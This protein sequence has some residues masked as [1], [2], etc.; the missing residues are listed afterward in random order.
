MANKW[1]NAVI[2]ICVLLAFGWWRM[3]Y[4]SAL[5]SE[6]RERELLP[7]PMSLDTRASLKQKG[8][9]STFGSLR[10]TLAAIMSLTATQYHVDS[11]WENLEREYKDI[12]LLDPGNVNYWDLGSWHIGTNA[13]VSSK[14]NTDYPPLK[15]QAMFEDYVHKGSDFLDQGILMSPKEW[16]LPF[17]KARMWANVHLIPDHELVLKTLRQALEYDN[18]PQMEA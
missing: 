17:L 5:S 6:M 11:D 9:A 15:R 3:G 14:E 13:A 8:L 1:L 10:P 4:E 12:V 16:R 2:V 18:V 7:A